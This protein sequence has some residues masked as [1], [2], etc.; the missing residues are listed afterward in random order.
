MPLLT[1]L[2]LLIV[3][4]R[5]IGR[6]FQR[7]HQPAIVG[8]MLA[9]ALLGPSVLDLIQPNAAL[10]GIS[11]LAVFLVV[12]SAGLEMK[13]NDIVSALRGRGAVIAVLGFAIPFF[14]GLLV[15]AAFRL[16]VMRTV[17]LGLCVSITALPV[18]I[19]ILQSFKTM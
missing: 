18:A 17:F 4:A 8:E 2:L 15:G 12:L 3:A 19:R 1:S 7:L 13:F 6:L 10:S 14:A 11:E 9:G 16:D 5:L